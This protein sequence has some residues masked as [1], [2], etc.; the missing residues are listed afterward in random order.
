MPWLSYAEQGLPCRQGH[1]AWVRLRSGRWQCRICNKARSLAW[2]KA[3]RDW[4]ATNVR[5]YGINP[6]EKHR[7][8]LIQYQCC[9]V[10]FEPIDLLGRNSHIDHDHKSR[11]VRGVLCHHCNI[12]IGLLR[13]DPILFAS[14][15]TYLG[16]H[17][18]TTGLA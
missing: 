18:A 8:W 6:E 5:R 3:H 1:D 13:E 2:G 4:A 10:C 16:G 7:L 12:A 15:V 17:C 9:A 14:A 11:K